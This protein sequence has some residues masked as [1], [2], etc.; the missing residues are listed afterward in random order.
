MPDY[1]SLGLGSVYHFTRRKTFSSSSLSAPCMSSPYIRIFY[2]ES[3]T[4]YLFTRIYI[5][6][7]CNVFPFILKTFT[8]YPSWLL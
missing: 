1:S 7:P 5:L 2:S 6:S 3:K 4:G 8:V